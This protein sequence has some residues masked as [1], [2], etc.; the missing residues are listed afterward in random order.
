MEKKLLFVYNPHSGKAH[1]KTYL[2]EIIEIYTKHGYCVTVHPTSRPNDGFVYMKENAKFYD[3]VSVCGG[4]GMLNE[5]VNA[6][7]TLPEDKRVSLAYLPSGSTNDFAGSVGLPTDL[8]Q[9]AQM[10]VEGKPFFCDAG[11]FNDRYFAYVAA[12]GAFT[13]V[14]YD[15]SQEFKNVFGHMAYIME[16]IRSLPN[17]HSYPVKIMTDGK[18]IEDEFLFGNFARRNIRVADRNKNAILPAF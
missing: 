13:S 8:R 10:A 18:V 4:D 3:L 12:F 7:M 9:S 11:K 1:I 16:G 2:A 5:A 14:A 15:T 6:L 17:I